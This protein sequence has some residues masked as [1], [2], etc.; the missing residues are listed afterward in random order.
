MT[1]EA[2][3]TGTADVTSRNRQFLVS[4]L[5]GGAVGAGGVVFG[6]WLAGPGWIRSLVGSARGAGLA[7]PVA[8]VSLA[9][10]AMLLVSGAMMLVLTLMPRRFAKQLKLEEGEDS[11]R[12][13]QMMRRGG[14]AS[15]VIAGLLLLFLVPAVSAA[16]GMGLLMVLLVY[17]AWMTV[18]IMRDG[19]ELYARVQIESWAMTA[20]VMQLVLLLWAGAA[21]FLGGP[22]ITPRDVVLLLV[23]TALATSAIVTARRGMMA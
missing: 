6:R 17:L 21:H 12:Q 2:T 15:F 14:W 19:D 1:E 10:A 13:L 22:A 7:D 23:I 8:L 4:M 11:R 5:I 9:L 3:G 16:V 18:L 20:V